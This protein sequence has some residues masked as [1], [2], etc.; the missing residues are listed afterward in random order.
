MKYI[1]V[2]IFLI[3]AFVGLITLF[4]SVSYFPGTSQMVVISGAGKAYDFPTGSDTVVVRLDVGEYI[5]GELQAL[6]DAQMSGLRSGTVRG[7]GFS[8]DYVQSLRFYEPGLFNGGQVVF[9]RD[10]SNQVSDFLEFK[11]A[12]FKFHVEFGSGLK[13][14]IE[15][16]SLPD[17]E[18]EDIFLLN[19]RFSI[20][21]TRISG[22]SV[23]LKL[24]G[25]YGSIVLRDNNFNDD[26]YQSYGAQVN[27]Q[28]IDALVKIR[29]S[30]INNQLT[31]YSIQYVLNANALIG[32]NVQVL[33]LHCTR[34]YLKY[35]QGL[36]SRSFDICYKGLSGAVASTKS[37]SGNKVEV[38]PSGDDEY[39]MYASNA[40]GSYYSIPLAQLPGLYGNKG[41]NF[42]FVE[43]PNQAAPNININDYF[44]LNSKQDINGV[45][46]VLMLDSINPTSNTVY[47]KDLATGARSATYDAATGAGELLSGEGNY[48]FVVTGNSL[49]IDQNN[50][51][52]INGGEAQF[53]LAGGSRIDFGPGFNVKVITPRRLFD[54]AVADEVTQFNILFGGDIDLNVP[55]P[56]NTIPGYTF[57]MVSQGGVRQALTKYG[58]L[59]TWDDYSSPPSDLS[60]TVPGAYGGPK[61]GAGADVFITLERAK[62][63]KPTQTPAPVAKC[64][65]KIITS[66][67]YCD[68]PG[69]VCADPYFGKAGICTNDCM[70]CV[71]PVCG[72]NLL[73]SG[74]ECEAAADCSVGFSCDG[75]KCIPLPKPVCGNNLLEKG[76][77]CE[78]DV[79]CGENFVCINCLCSP[80]PI[81]QPPVIETPAQIK[82]PNAIARFFSWLA[83]LFGA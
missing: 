48:R 26:S 8:A 64:G 39:V 40:R 79:D 12:V 43:A 28:D 6:S 3:V 22:N 67:E 19:E 68:P 57:K 63:M 82:Q 77:Q 27:G 80:A 65:D 11:D 81:I 30:L 34:E 78:Y 33:P 83:R 55:S 14:D 2:S 70:K 10:E 18:D 38:R 9:G 62:L 24:F 69:S 5:S 47:F 13:S 46:N 49:A 32:G 44:L 56:Q 25:G 66:P 45:S 76:E 50:D 20:V 16:S 36:L 71:I 72:N 35:P 17:I 58:I 59:W 7:K 42:V 37:I 75:C 31:I 41:R 29:A 21:D 4:L 54:D 60:L 15:G 73:E 74:E 23:E 52:N 61:G 51:G 1:P 53:V